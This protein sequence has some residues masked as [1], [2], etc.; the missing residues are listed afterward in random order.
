MDVDQD[1]DNVQ[2]IGSLEDSFMQTSREA[3]KNAEYGQRWLDENSESF[4]QTHVE[5]VREHV[6]DEGIRADTYSEY[7][8]N[9]DLYRY[10]ESKKASTAGSIFDGTVKGVAAAAGYGDPFKSADFKPMGEALYANRDY[11]KNVLDSKM[12]AVVRVQDPELNRDDI[13][14]PQTVIER[15]ISEFDDPNIDFGDDI[16]IDDN[17]EI[18]MHYDDGGLN[19]E[20]IEYRDT[21]ERF[22]LSKDA[23]NLVG[24]KGTDLYDREMSRMA[25][26]RS[27]IIRTLRDP[28]VELTSYERSALNDYLRQTEYDVEFL[29]GSGSAV[30]Y[31]DL[32]YHNM[33]ELESGD[34]NI[35]RKD[36]SFWEG[37]IGNSKMYSKD[38]NVSE[39][40]ARYGQDGVEYRNNNPDFRPFTKQYDE[41]F[42][43]FDSE[44]PITD[45]KGVSDSFGNHFNARGMNETGDLERDSLTLSDLGNF[46]QADLAL[47]KRLN[48]DPADIR[49]YRTENNM[50]WHEC[51]DGVTMQLIPTEINGYFN[52]YGGTSL[53]KELN[54]DGRIVRDYSG[55]RTRKS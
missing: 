24:M 43:Y 8:K 25:T 18:H 52:H 44:V 48:V 40:L 17:H 6:E 41:K 4:D 50:T 13:E 54:T 15:N 19:A 39:I 28:N 23:E 2:E 51:R 37:E 33:E 21:L 38:S 5:S 27:E 47:S 26:E 49:S 1:V 42:G 45:M 20:V 46:A 10:D 12:D 35:L 29:N 36:P 11:Y 34:Y 7:A 9:P 53:M 32:V 30:P 3:R 55:L 16:R 14:F 22:S 31:R